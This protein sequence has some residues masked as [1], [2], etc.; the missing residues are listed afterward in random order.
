VEPYEGEQTVLQAVTKALD[1]PA[2]GKVQI[3]ALW[4]VF[5][6]ALAPVRDALS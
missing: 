4:A 2:L 3:G 1:S 5:G 6:Q